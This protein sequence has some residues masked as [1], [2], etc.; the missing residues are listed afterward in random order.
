MTA[1]AASAAAASNTH[2]EPTPQSARVQLLMYNGRM[3]V[4]IV[5][6]DGTQEPFDPEKLKTSLRRAG[7]SASAVEHVLAEVTDDLT[8]GTTTGEIYHQAF[9][10]LKQYESRE[11]A[12]RYSVKRA[13]FRLGPTGYPFE[14]FVSEILAAEGYSTRTQERVDG[15]CTWHEVDI[16]ACDGDTCFGVEA[17]FHNEQG[18]KTDVVDTLYVRARYTDIVRAGDD[19]TDGCLITN[20]KFSSQAIEYGT[21]AGLGMVGW[22]YPSGNTLEDRIARTG[23]RPVTALTSLTDEECRAL[24]KENIV[25]CKT[26]LEQFEMLDTLE[27]PNDRQSV[28]KE[29]AHH[30]CQPTADN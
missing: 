4:E 10:I 14:T 11:S 13:L 23:V 26:L 5:K 1:I 17:K 15:K 3:A 21:C 19:I 8:D 20:T 22:N 18:T 16:V 9:R 12:A 24:L 25:L 29:E 28:V 7:A 6:A 30:L 27:V 2:P